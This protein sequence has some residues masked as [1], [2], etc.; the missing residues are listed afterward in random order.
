MILST[1]DAEQQRTKEVDIC[2]KQKNGK[3]NAKNHRTK[4]NVSFRCYLETHGR[5]EIT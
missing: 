2:D 4:L 5:S 1:I 3:I